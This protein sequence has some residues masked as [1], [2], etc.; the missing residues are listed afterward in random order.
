MSVESG[1]IS[2]P[3]LPRQ[4]TQTIAGDPGTQLETYLQETV[5]VPPETIVSSEAPFAVPPQQGPKH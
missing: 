5:T 3:F 2:L 4:R 1:S